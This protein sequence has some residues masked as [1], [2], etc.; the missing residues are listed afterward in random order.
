MN[1]ASELKVSERIIV[2]L[3]SNT[4]FTIATCS[5]NIPYCANCFYAYDEE[6]NLIFFKSKI[7]TKHIRQALENNNVA[8]SITPD[9]LDTATIQG[10]QFNGNF[11]E[12]QNELL[13]RLKKMYYKKYS[14][15][16]ALPGNLWAIK[17]SY[18]KMTDN[19]LGFGTTI[20]WSARNPEGEIM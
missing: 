15:A 13:N 9:K 10:I 7:K 4:D 12:P 14:F 1:K 2:F 17:L 20:E 8:G 16:I 5:N 11:I 19:T 18:I 3:K 6:Q